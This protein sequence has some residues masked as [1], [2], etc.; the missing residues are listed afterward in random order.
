[1]PQVEGFSLGVVGQPMI[2]CAHQGVLQN[3]QLIRV[4]PKVIE[5]AL[6]EAR[7]DLAAADAHRAFDGGLLV[8]AVEPGNEVF[9]L[10]D[11]LG[12]FLELRAVTKKVGAHREHDVHGQLLLAGSLDEYLDE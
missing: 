1:M 5:Q 10:V 7:C 9:A 2:P 11:R 12:Q 6:Y 8:F 4:V 3:W